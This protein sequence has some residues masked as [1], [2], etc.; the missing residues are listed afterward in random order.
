MA[1]TGVFYETVLT[2]PRYP[3][4]Y[5]FIETFPLSFLG[6]RVQ[7]LTL[8]SHCLNLMVFHFYILW[9]Y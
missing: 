4:H 9:L 6:L 2:G 5:E 1:K 7:Y 3:E 8:S